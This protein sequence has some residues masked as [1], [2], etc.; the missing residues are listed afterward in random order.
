MAYIRNGHHG[1]HIASVPLLWLHQLGGGIVVRDVQPEACWEREE[2]D[3]SR[4]RYVKL[5]IRLEL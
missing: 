4:F 3:F 5:A 1:I 2:A